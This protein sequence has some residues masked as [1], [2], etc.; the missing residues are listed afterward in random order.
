M[1]GTVRRAEVED[2]PALMRIRSG[3]REN[4][5]SDPAKVPAAA[6]RTFIDGPGIW[7]WDEDGSVLGFSAAD[8]TDGTIWALFVDPAAE[9]LGIGGELL[10]CALDDLRASGWTESRLSTGPGTRADEFYRR[11]GWVDAGMSVS[12]ERLL[13]KAL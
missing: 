4:R 8:T 10:S 2:I 9:G 13:A 12:G 1:A 7:L 11:R 3:V 6:Y 5:L